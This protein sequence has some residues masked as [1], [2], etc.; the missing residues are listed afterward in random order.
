M[1]AKYKRKI[2]NLGLGKYISIPKCLWDNWNISDKKNPE[3]TLEID[4]KGNL[5]IKNP[6]NEA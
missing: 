5:I 1:I 3:L 6:E 4:S 2:Q